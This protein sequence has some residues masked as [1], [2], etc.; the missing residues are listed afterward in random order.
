MA[1]N[2]LNA[3]AF[4]KLDEAQMAALGR[5]PLTK[6]KRLQ[7]GEKLFEVGDPDIN[8]LVVKSGAVEIVDE[9][10][11]KPRT[12]TVL[13]HGEFTGDVTQLTG[14]PAVVSGVA[15]GNTEVYE[16][17]PD[18]LRHL[19]NN[20][21][22]LGDVILQAFI[23]RRQLLRESGDYTG[24]R[25]IGSRVFSRH[26]PGPRLPGQEPGSVHLAGSGGRSA[27]QSDPPALRGDG[28]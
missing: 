1:E 17:S 14:G 21:P 15:R 11:E 25:V 16:V 9:S 22:E 24:P 19:L 5:C 28:I 3:V 10:G 13:G 7:D 20:H 27:G 8:F 4:P 6:L 26:L 2:D 23:A 18:A 12:I